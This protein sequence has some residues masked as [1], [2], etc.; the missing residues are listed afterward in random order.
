MTAAAVIVGVSLAI[1]VT[2][3]ALVWRRRVLRR[4]DETAEDRYRR[5][6]PDIRGGGIHPGGQ[7]LKPPRPNN[8]PS[9][10]A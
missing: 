1:I 2:I 7:P 4:R 6:I 3:G 10:G 5:A 8:P 9:A